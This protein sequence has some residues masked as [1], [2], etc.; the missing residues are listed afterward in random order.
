ME[1]LAAFVNR[2]DLPP[3]V[4]AA[5]AHA[6]RSRFRAAGSCAPAPPFARPPPRR[7]CGILAPWVELRSR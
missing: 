2:T 5:I 3:L 7:P 4:Q 6:R 1:H